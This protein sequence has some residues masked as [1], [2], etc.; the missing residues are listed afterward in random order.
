M[1]NLTEIIRLKNKYKCY[2]YIDEAHSIGAVGGRGRGVCDYFG[3]DP[4]DID[5]LMGT[6]SKSFSASGGYIAGRK[7]VI[8]HIVSESS[9][10]I[11]STSMAPCIAKQI[12][13]V[14]NVIMDDGLLNDGRSTNLNHQISYIKD[15]EGTLKIIRNILD[16]CMS[17]L[18]KERTNL[19]LKLK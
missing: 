14:F 1:V 4:T 9:D 12:Y 16:K 15:D 10:A 19:P 6:F 5:V 8:D 13:S 18:I 7:R 3:C 11:Y 2:L 17:K